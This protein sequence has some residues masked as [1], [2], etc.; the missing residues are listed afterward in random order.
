MSNIKQYLVIVIIGLMGLGLISF[1]I[2]AET[3]KMSGTTPMQGVTIDGVLNDAEWANLDVDVS[4]FLDIDDVGN[5]PDADGYNNLY[6]GEDATNLYI[7]LD[8][9]SDRTG[10]T[11]GEWVGVWLNT[12]NRSF[13]NYIEWESYLNNGTE[14]LVY[15]VENDRNWEFLSDTIGGSLSRVNDDSEYAATYGTISGN[16]TH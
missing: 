1:S 9:T 13:I 6:I 2:S 11:N 5:P 10:G 16:T 7:G 3:P 4:I 14:S 8:L 15:D 12:N